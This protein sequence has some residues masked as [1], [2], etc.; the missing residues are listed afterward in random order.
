LRGVRFSFK[1]QLPNV[2]EMFTQTPNEETKH[3]LDVKFQ[4][5]DD[6]NCGI[7]FFIPLEVCE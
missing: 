2:T 1:K 3:L 7:V 4:S 6:G 5:S